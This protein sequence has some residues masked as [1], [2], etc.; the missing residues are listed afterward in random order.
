VRRAGGSERR[1]VGS[2]YRGGPGACSE[3]RGA[4]SQPAIAVCDI[5]PAAPRH[6]ESAA[7]HVRPHTCGPTRALGR[8]TE[9][10]KRRAQRYLSIV[11]RAEEESASRRAGRKWR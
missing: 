5:K 1:G 8:R 11:E 6:A 4:K 7:P 9:P 10:E 2:E 3:C